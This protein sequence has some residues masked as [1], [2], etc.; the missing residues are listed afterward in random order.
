MQNLRRG[1]GNRPLPAE[2]ATAEKDTS[3]SRPIHNKMGRGRH[4]QMW[5]RTSPMSLGKLCK[6]PM[7]EGQPPLQAR[8][9][10]GQ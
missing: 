5:S 3:P 4:H 6:W 7:R 1:K 2:K 10:L 9:R 8:T